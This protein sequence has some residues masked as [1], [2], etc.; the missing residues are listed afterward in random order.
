VNYYINDTV[1]LRLFFDTPNELAVALVMLWGAVLCYLSCCNDENPGSIKIILLEKI[2]RSLC[3]LAIVIVPL[4]CLFATYSRSGM[5]AFLGVACALWR[6]RGTREWIVIS[7]IVCALCLVFMPNAG[8]RFTRIEPVSDK[9]IANRFDV[10]R[11]TLAMSLEKPWAGH[12]PGGFGEMLTTWYLPVNGSNASYMTAVNTPLT[13]LGFFGYPALFAYLFLW[14]IL[15]IIGL[16]GFC[17]G[18]RGVAACFII[19]LAFLI[20]GL[21]ADLHQSWILDCILLASIGGTVF[22][23]LKNASG[24]KPFYK[25]WGVVSSTASAVTCGLMVAAGSL[26][27]SEGYINRCE[28]SGMITAMGKEWIK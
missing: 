12:G 11:G 21:F 23:H 28:S 4:V 13:V 6:S 7:L 24:W 22:F 9:S 5:V 8:E 15:L 26:L 16:R 25:R 20:G 1:R 17:H 27:F 18:K 19:Q 14:V 2:V 10:W 3:H